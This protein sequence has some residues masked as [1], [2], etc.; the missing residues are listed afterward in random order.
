M[1]Y[2][3]PYFDPNKAHHT[4]SGFRNLENDQI[5]Q[6]DVRRW[7]WNR[8]LKRLPLPPKMGYRAFEQLW[9]QTPDFSGTDDMLWWL[10]H[11]SFYFR[12]GGKYFLIDPTFSGRASPFSFAGPKRKVKSPVQIADLPGLDVL[13][14]SHNH[15]DHLDSQTIRHIKRHYP[16]VSIIVPLG[17]KTWFRQRGFNH[18]FEYDWHDKHTEHGVNIYPT[19]ARHWS[20]RSGFDRN[21][22]LWCG[23]ILEYGDWRFY[24]TGDS[25]YSDEL[26]K[27]RQRYGEI[28]MAG[29][30]I[31]AYAPKWFM[32][33]QH[34]DPDDAVK[35]FR[36]LGEPLT[37]AMHWGVFEL[38]DE[39]IDEPPAHLRQSLTAQG[40]TSGRFM[41]V[42][43]GAR[44][45]ITQT[46][47]Y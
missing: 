14:L 3:N 44:M 25:G 41:L 7:Q 5:L 40:V 24:F 2:K 42:K 11:A 32:H 12:L 15:F 30:P 33:Q 46:T 9:V 21:Q 10:G 38:A 29:L 16:Q 28:S 20:V 23:F 6:A 18:V 8:Q 34:M 13:M 35:L 1:F 45:P 31:G 17:L 27:V 36:Q 37:I 47:S 19:P 43:Q 22:S 26:A 39:P 4:P